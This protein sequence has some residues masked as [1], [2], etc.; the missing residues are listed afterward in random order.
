ML[1]KLKCGNIFENYQSDKIELTFTKDAVRHFLQISI[2]LEAKYNSS[3]SNLMEKCLITKS[4]LTLLQP[5]YVF[6]QLSAQ[7]GTITETQNG[8]YRLRG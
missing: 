8:D 5:E 2:N 7:A 3:S 1:L 6:S 4:S